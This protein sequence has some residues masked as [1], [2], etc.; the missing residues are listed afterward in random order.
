MRH[1]A[2]AACL[3]TSAALAEEANFTDGPPAEWKPTIGDWTVADGVLTGREVAADNH[4]AAGRWFIPIRD[5]RVAFR[6][7]NVDAKAVNFGFDPAKG[8]LDKKGHL[9]SVVLTPEKAQVTLSRDKA[10][11]A[12]KNK[13]LAAAAVDLPKGEWH[14][15]AVDFDGETAK[16]TVG[17]QTL[18]ATD[19][20]IRVKKTGLILRVSGGSV[21]FDD[22][23]IAPE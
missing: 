9:F 14:T 17:G 20:Q 16:I 4:A 22:L 7:R 18:V 1:A 12:S 19:P 21:E 2:L 13:R 5:G 23:V 3:L 8:E 6:F 15:V 11:E 10:D